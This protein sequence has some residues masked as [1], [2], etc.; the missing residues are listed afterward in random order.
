MDTKIVVLNQGYDQTFQARE[1]RLIETLAGH[2]ELV[3]SFSGRLESCYAMDLCRASGVRIRALTLDNPLL[4]RREL[5]RARRYCKHHGIDQRVIK[6]DEMLFCDTGQLPQ[7]VRDPLQLLGEAR[8]LQAEWA[9]LPLLIP[10][11]VE[12][13]QAY[14]GHFIQLPANTLWPFAEQGMSRRDFRYGFHRRELD[15]WGKTSG[16]YL[17]RRF[18]DINEMEGRHA[19]MIDM[20]EQLLADMGFDEAQVFFHGLGG[21][22][23][24]LARIRLPTHLRAHGFDCQQEIYHT[25]KRMAFAHVT[26]D[27]AQPERHDLQGRGA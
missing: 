3:V 19:Q 4:S 13:M 21:G 12:E 24:A 9:A 1:Q 20:A 18:Q 10:A 26:L 17:N 7:T 27:L 14:L 22:H 11:P 6:S 23:G 15:R 5:A 8:A 2:G 16:G 25:L